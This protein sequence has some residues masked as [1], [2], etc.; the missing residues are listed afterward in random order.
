[1]TPSA[2]D[3]KYLVK[4]DEDIFLAVPDLIKAVTTSGLPRSWMY[5]LVHPKAPIFRRQAEF[6]QWAVPEYVYPKEELP[7][8]C[9]G[10]A[11][12]VSRPAAECLY[13]C[14]L[15]LEMFWEKNIN[16]VCSLHSCSCSYIL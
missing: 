13:R 5:C 7:R 12:V 2:Q 6:P 3:F 10:P 8:Y 11:Y 16:V 4:A 1:M 9:N 15:I 14:E